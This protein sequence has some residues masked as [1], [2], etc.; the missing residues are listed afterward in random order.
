MQVLIDRPTISYRSPTLSFPQSVSLRP[1]RPAA[2]VN[3]YNEWDPLEEVIVGRVED[4]CI[5]EWHAILGATMPAD[6]HHFFQRH[7][8]HKFGEQLLYAAQQEL[9][10][11]VSI[12]Q[13]EGV[14]VQR[15]A[16]LDWSTPFTTPTFSQPAGLYAAMPRDFLLVVGN[17]LIESPMAWRSRY[18]EFRAYRPLLKHYFTQGA[19]WTAAPKPELSEALYNYDYALAR[20]EYVITEFEP[21]FDA[22][23]FMRCGRDIFCQKSHVTNQ[24]GIDWLQSHLGEEYQIHI[25]DFDDPKAMHI[26]ATFVP[27]APGRLLLNATRATALPPMFDTWE[28]LTPPPP[29][30]PDE[31]PLYFTSKWVSINVL[32]LDEERV[33]VEEQEEP[34]IR[35][36]RQHGFQPIPVPFRNFMSMGGAFHC[37]TVDIRRRGTL[38]CYF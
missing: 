29:V 36:L 31:H 12:L 7:G 32:S 25:L 4:A 1:W 34:L 17:E 19:K 14:T 5:P 3:S 30:I 20:G 11:L 37:A 8:G 35:F 26:D 38:Q 18:F 15:P 23:D 6:Q 28:I 10:Q 33:V 13:G 24:F 9:E 16:A 22:A 21:V 27:L 2:V